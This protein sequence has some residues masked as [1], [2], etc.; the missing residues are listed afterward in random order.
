MKKHETLSA[1]KQLSLVKSGTVDFISEK[2]LLLKLNKQGGLRIKAGFDPSRPDLH[3]GHLV[4]LNKLKMFQDMGHTVLLLVGD[5]TAQIGDPTGSDKTRP[6]LSSR[7]VK[8]NAKTYLDQVFSVLDKKTTQVHFNSEWMES[9]SVSE[10]VTLSSQHTVARMLE[11]EDFSQRFKK[12]RSIGIHEFL[13]PLIQAYD[14]LV[15]KADVE[16][17]GTDQIFN[18]LLGR[19]IQKKSGLS[20][21]CVITLPILPGT[22]GVKKMSKSYDNFI[23]LKDSPKDMF[24]KT[25]KI[26]DDLMLC[27]F[28]LLTDKNLKQIK[29]LKAG[30]KSKSLHPRDLKVELASFLVGKFYGKQAACVQAEEF[31][32]VF[33]S[34]QMPSEMSVFKVKPQSQ[35]WIAY[36]MKQSGL[37]SSTSEAQRLIQSRAL[38]LKGR[39]VLNPRLMLDLK[40][41]EEFVLQVGKRRFVK[42]CVQD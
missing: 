1:E 14:S 15:L 10:L 34:S 25:M 33:S 42:V 28:E 22:D 11:R 23:S 30:L 29:E 3:L 40:T 26:N 38:S 20:P 5:F 21:Q 27:Y 39:K 6:L 16:L 31:K 13:Y 7:E 41:G 36:L 18:L 12:Q 19:E 2:E 17:G 37:C 8:N 9:M 35:L 24:G 4:V 32:K